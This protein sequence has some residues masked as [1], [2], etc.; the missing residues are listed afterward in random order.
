MNK[1]LRNSALSAALLA[2]AAP[3]AAQDV[4]TGV[5]GEMEG[6]YSSHT[7][8]TYTN[9]T[10]KTVNDAHFELSIRDLK[11]WNKMNGLVVTS[12]VASGIT[13]TEDGD[14]DRSTVRVDMAFEGV[15]PNEV[16]QFEAWYWLDKQNVFRQGKI[17]WTIDGEDVVD[18]GGAGGGGGDPGGGGGD[19]GGGDPGGGGGTG[20]GYTGAA[21]GWDVAD[22]YVC[23]LFW[24]HDIRIWNEGD[25]ERIYDD[26]RF[27]AS[28]EKY[29]DLDS[30][31]WIAAETPF[32]EP[33][34]VAAGEYLTHQIVTETRMGAGSIYLST[35]WDDGAVRMVGE[36]PV[37]PVPIPAAGALL[38][39]ALGGL[40]A[41]R[42]ARR[43]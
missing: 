34:T 12:E 30:V 10:G 3:A 4:G 11:P 26:L 27:L 25:V 31:D 17:T 1:G 29:W 9:T 7:E 14:A 38:A 41:L 18:D 22:P 16:L 2:G 8:L 23:G 5:W 40:A 6:G 15:D 42:R 21:G 33:V 36:H 37:D 24:C 28:W 35:T 32:A 20:G 39:G 19:P 13:L 43:S